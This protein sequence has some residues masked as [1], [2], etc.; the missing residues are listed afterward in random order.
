MYETGN[1]QRDCARRAAAHRAAGRLEDAERE[2]RAGLD[3]HAAWTDGM[4]LLALVLLERDRVGEA[5]ELLRDWVHTSGLEARPTPADA[6]STFAGEVSDRELEDA[7]A[8]A[9]TD[10]DEVFDADAIA[11]RAMREADFEL[12]DL[13]TS[14]SMYATRTMASLL[15]QQG[16]ERGA[17]RIRA[18]ARPAASEATVSKRKSETIDELERWLVNLRGGAQ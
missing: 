14:D 3:R 17:S 5:R 11:Q 15:E 18:L 10:P 2:L 6:T 12:E 7:F 4:S 1:A 13:A 9:E 16:D 8:A